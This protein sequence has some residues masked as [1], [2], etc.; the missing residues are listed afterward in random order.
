M[1]AEWYEFGCALE[2]SITDLDII[3]DQGGLQ[4][5]MIAM[6]KEWIRI[7][8]SEATWENMQEALKSIGNNRLAASLQ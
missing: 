1:T 6:L 7:K 3:K 2:V 8:K 4:R 5:Y